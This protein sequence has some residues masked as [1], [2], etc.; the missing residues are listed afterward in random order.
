MERYL[1]KNNVLENYTGSKKS[2][3]KR[4]H[5]INSSKKFFWL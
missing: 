5:T 1:F 2:K 3:A 4:M